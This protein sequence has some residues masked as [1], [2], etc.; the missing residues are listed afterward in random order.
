MIILETIDERFVTF[1]HFVEFLV[2]L[3]TLFMEE[4]SLES[5]SE[6]IR[7]LKRR[8]TRKVTYDLVTGKSNALEFLVEVNG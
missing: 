2:E 1:N 8:I 5:C 4:K 6:F 7:M 3:S